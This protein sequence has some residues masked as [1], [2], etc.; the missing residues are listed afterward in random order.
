MAVPDVVLTVPPVILTV[1]A[2]V[3]LKM[4]LPFAQLIVPP[5]IIS[6]FVDWLRIAYLFVSA[7][8]I[9]MSAVLSTEMSFLTRIVVK[10]LDDVTFPDRVIL[11]QPQEEPCTVSNLTSPFPKLKVFVPS[12]KRMAQSWPCALVRMVSIAAEIVL[13]PTAVIVNVAPL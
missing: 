1:A 11:P 6:G 8:V 5:P 7:E 10:E 13:G 9:S 12:P 2:L 3:L 4:A